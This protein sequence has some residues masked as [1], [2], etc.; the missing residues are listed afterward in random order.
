MNIKLKDISFS[1]GMAKIRVSGK[2]GQR[3]IPVIKAE[4]LIR[5]Q[6]ENHPAKSNPEA[7]LWYRNSGYHGRLS[8]NTIH[9][10][11][12]TLSRKAGI[13]KKTNPH[14]FRHA[15][16]TKLAEIFNEAQLREFFGWTKN[17]DMPSTYIHLS[18]KSIEDPLLEQAGLKEKNNKES[19]VL[20]QKVCPKCK[21]TNPATRTFCIECETPL[22]LASAMAYDEQKTAMLKL[23]VDKMWSE[24]LKGTP[25]TTEN[26]TI[27]NNNELMLI[28]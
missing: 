7:Y 16:A 13:K 22:D 2:T 26:Y 19:E 5:Q 12:K 18:S 3:Q 9:S 15:R 4:S 24:M 20:K 25:L 6:I 10:L 11:L 1:N 27:G 23:L 14:S 8:W 21:K 17:S 28:K